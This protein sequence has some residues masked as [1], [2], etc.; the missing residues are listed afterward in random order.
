MTQIIASIL[1]PNYTY[2]QMK[3]KIATLKGHI[4]TIQIDLCDGKFTPSITWPFNSGGFEDVHFKRIL[5]EEEGL[6]F[7]EDVDFELDLMVSDA[8]ENF[9]MY[10]KLGA[11]AVIFHLEAMKDQ[12]EFK[13][14]LEGIDIYVRDAVE[15]GVA[16]RPGTDLEE[17]YPLVPHVD[18]VQVMG[19]DKVGEAG[20]ALD[21]KVYERIRTIRA[22]YSDLPI[23]V[24]IGVTKDTAPL[25]VAAGA[26]KLV[27]GSAIFN[28]G[29]IMGAIEYF[30]NL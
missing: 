22:R 28:S 20:V 23:E 16:F 25:L 24:D 3:N 2:E 21:E 5:D 26:T 7:W 4:P 1:S 6:P 14:F 12:G 29:D 18:F 27:A 9:D 10:M 15:V 8:V 19:N 11:K 17:F 13:N 30:K